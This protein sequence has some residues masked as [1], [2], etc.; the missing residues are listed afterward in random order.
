MSVI[1]AFGLWRQ[2][3]EEFKVIP[4]YM[5]NWRLAWSSPC[6]QTHTH[7]NKIKLNRGLELELRA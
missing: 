2:K 5:V 3:D 1:A 6:L 7:I 4:I